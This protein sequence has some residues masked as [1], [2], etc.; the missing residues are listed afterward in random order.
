[1]PMTYK[2][3]DLHIWREGDR[4]AAEV[5]H[6]PVGRTATREYLSW[7]FGNEP[8]RLLLVHLE[9]AILKSKNSRSGPLLS[10]EEKILREFG[11]DLFKCVFRDSGGVAEM[12]AGSLLQ[13]RDQEDVGLRINLRVDPPEMAS[14]PWE[15]VFDERNTPRNYLCLRSRS[16]VVRRLG[17]SAPPQPI[18]AHAPVRVLAMLVNLSGEWSLRDAEKER[19]HLEAIFQTPGLP[20]EFC[21][22]LRAT[23]DSLFDLMQQGPWDIFHFIGHGGTEHV[24]DPEGNRYSEGYVVMDDGAGGAVKVLASTLADMLEDGQVKLAVLNCCEG[25]R[26][27]SSVGAALVAAGIPMAIAMQFAITDASAARF[28]ERFYKS[29]AEGQT[30]E[31][32]LTVAR[33]Y[34]HFTSD[35]EWAI[36]VLFTQANSSTFFSE[37]TFVA[38]SA[39]P[40]PAAAPPS[41][42]QAASTSPL[43]EAD[44]AHAQAELRRL[45]SR[46]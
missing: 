19:R 15:Y 33:K 40:S 7:P 20:V 13:I 46:V 8:D 9:N 26:G 45:W 42:A 28:S 5:T 35:A 6:S 10:P 18:R 27:S 14:L 24:T 36:P 2:D 38:P 1:M 11:A 34:M 43:T 3:F 39:A 16:P 22:N 4:Y 44:R 17:T 25:A 32:A 41:P 31:R 37:P 29:L 23:P 30:V 12:Y 21:W